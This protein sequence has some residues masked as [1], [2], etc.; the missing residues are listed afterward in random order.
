M[1]YAPAKFEVVTYAHPMV[2]EEMHLQEMFSRGSLGVTIYIYQPCVFILF[3]YQPMLNM[4]SW[5][6]GQKEVSRT[7]T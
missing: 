6:Q 7:I 3:L 4:W 2:L 1:T 5:G